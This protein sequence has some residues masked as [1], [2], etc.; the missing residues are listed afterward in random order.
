MLLS[1]RKRSSDGFDGRRREREDL[2]LDDLLLLL[3]SLPDGL[4]E[5]LRS[6]DSG[7]RRSLLLSYNGDGGFLSEFGSLGSGRRSER[8]L[9][10]LDGDGSGRGE[11][12]DGRLEGSSEI[13]HGRLWVLLF[14]FVLLLLLFILEFH[15]LLGRTRTDDWGGLLLAS[16]DG[17]SWDGRDGGGEGL[18]GGGGGCFSNVGELGG[19]SLSER[20]PE[21]SDGRSGSDGSSSD[22]RESSGS[23]SLRG[24]ILDFLLE[25]TDPGVVVGRGAGCTGRGEHDGES[26]WDGRSRRKS[27]ERVGGGGVVVD[28]RELGSSSVEVVVLLRVLT[29]VLVEGSRRSIGGKLSRFPLVR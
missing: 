8:D 17:R 13:G 27:G 4:G 16:D 7:G 29:L 23:S 28:S 3:G 20:H 26:S 25:S 22:G 6:L 14:F 1:S 24:E 10:S 21:S 5:L 2:G 15:L 18:G 9:R 19:R 11:T 12:E